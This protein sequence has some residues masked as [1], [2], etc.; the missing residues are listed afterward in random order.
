[1]RSRYNSASDVE[2]EGRGNMKSRIQTAV[3]EAEAVIVM[4]RQSDVYAPFA[5][6]HDLPVW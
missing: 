5:K 6:W 2:E 1:M 4:M 3:A